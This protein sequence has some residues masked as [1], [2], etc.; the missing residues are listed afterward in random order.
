MIVGERRLQA[1]KI[2]HFVTIPA[3]VKDI[4]DK[5]SCEI[6]LVENIDRENLTAIEIAQ[7]LK[8]LIDEFNYTQET[9]ATLFSVAI[10]YC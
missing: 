1:C 4:S 8:Q 6:A 3:I 9:L 10:K 7:S 2:N 5:E